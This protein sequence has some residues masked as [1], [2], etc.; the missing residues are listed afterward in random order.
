MKRRNKC[1]K[2]KVLRIRGG[3]RRSFD[4]D[5]TEQTEDS[6]ETANKIGLIHPDQAPVHSRRRLRL[7][8]EIT[9]QKGASRSVST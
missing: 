4:K 5:Q 7:A 1:K 3:Y 2:W 8:L 6:K 9:T